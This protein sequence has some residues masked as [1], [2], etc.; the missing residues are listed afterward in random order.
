MDFKSLL[1]KLPLDKLPEGAKSQVEEIKQKVDS[2]EL[3]VDDAKAKLS[4]LTLGLDLGDIK[5]KIGDS[6]GD[7]VDKAKGLFGK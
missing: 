6:A 2:G 3:G 1:D 4:E 5:D 7:L